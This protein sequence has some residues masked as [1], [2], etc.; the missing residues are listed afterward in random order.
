VDRL[1][2]GD[3]ET[4]RSY[5][6]AAA[7]CKLTATRARSPRIACPR[8]DGD[9]GAARASV[10]SVERRDFHRRAAPRRGAAP[11]SAGSCG[12]RASCS[13]A[14]LHRYSRPPSSVLAVRR[15]AI[16]RRRDEEVDDRDVRPS[17]AL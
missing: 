9:P 6:R 5:T 4:V 13:R 14:P 3:P 10:R 2:A 15:P 16:Y 7:A 8:S 17:R 11:R 12:A 1:A